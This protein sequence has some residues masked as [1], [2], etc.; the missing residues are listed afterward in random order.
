MLIDLASI[1]KEG[2]TCEFDQFSSEMKK[3]FFDLIGKSPFKIHIVIKPMA[4]AFKISG[5]F[6]SQSKD[7]CSLCGHDIHYPIKKFN[8]RNYCY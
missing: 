3:V 5:S 8:Q 4:N 6:E 2:L 1:G 7:I